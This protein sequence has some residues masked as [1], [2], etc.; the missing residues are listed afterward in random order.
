MLYSVVVLFKSESGS[1]SGFL[2]KPFWG[3][4]YQLPVAIGNYS[5]ERE[6]AKS[7]VNMMM[8]SD[9]GFRHGSTR[10]EKLANIEPL[11]N[12]SGCLDNAK[13]LIGSAQ[14]YSFF[15]YQE[16]EWQE[17]CVSEAEQELSLKSL[18]SFYG[19]PAS[20]EVLAK[21][22]CINNFKAYINGPTSVLES[23]IAEAVDVRVYGNRSYEDHSAVKM[24]CDWWNENVD[25]ES[26]KCAKNFCLYYWDTKSGMFISCDDEEPAY[27]FEEMQKNKC[28]ASFDYHNTKVVAAF[29]KSDKNADK[30]DNFATT[31]MPDGEV[32]AQ[33]GCKLNE[34]NTSCISISCL[35]YLPKSLLAT[36]IL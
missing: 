11:D 1:F 10:L 13:E 16:Y 7:F 32:W 30:K 36:T 18:T 12:I 33:M 5:Y 31:Y 23:A 15:V 26:L 29:I 17:G 25:D 6:G 4:L 27:A 22:P 9:V 24:L 14:F 35:Q 34:I 21:A 28:L 8:G 2:A 19:T 3:D 20:K